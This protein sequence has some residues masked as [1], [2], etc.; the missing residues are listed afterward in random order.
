MSRHTDFDLK[1]FNSWRLSAFGQNVLLPDT[2]H[3]LKDW[4]KEYKTLGL[5]LGLGSNV[6]LPETVKTPI[7][8][9]QKHLSHL[10]LYLITRFT[11]NVALHVHKFQSSVVN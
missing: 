6:L 3:E 9:T 8:I 2:Y 10:N 1:K 5:W 7:V 11:L 4:I